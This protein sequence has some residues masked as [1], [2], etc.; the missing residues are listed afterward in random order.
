MKYSIII[1]ALN[2]SKNITQCLKSVTQ[3]FP[4][5]EVI[6]VDGGSSDQ[7]ANLAQKQ[8]A[9]IVI[10]LK[11]RGCQL[12]GGAHRAR[13]EILIFLHADT[14]LPSD[15]KYILDR[16]FSA[17]SVQIGTFGMRFDKKHWL[18]NLY[19]KMTRFDS[20]MTSFGDQG[21]A[22]RKSFFDQLGGF[23]NW[24][25]FEDVRFL[26]EARKQT[27]IHSFP[28][29]VITSS[30]KFTKNGILK[31]QLRNG[32]LIFQYYR[33]VSPQQLFQRYYA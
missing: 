20:L 8:G 28:A 1:P 9:F 5:E 19:S 18:L 14:Q 23:P 11:G 12:N 16:Y 6:V 26:E 22:V 13:G 27:T 33:G 2:E 7:T 31:Q 21:I 30:R 4:D 32:W 29:D 24:P 25:L 15:A 10:G 17:E 3:I